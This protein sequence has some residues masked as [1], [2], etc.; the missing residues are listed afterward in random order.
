MKQQT[1]SNKQAESRD[2]ILAGCL[3][4]LFSTLKKDAGYSS[5]SSYVSL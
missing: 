4:G 1:I 3:L 5:D 2:L